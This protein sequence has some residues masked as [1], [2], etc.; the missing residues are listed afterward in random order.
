[1]SAATTAHVRTALQHDQTIPSPASTSSRVRAS[2]PL[3]QGNGSVVVPSS[4]GSFPRCSPIV[5]PALLSRVA[6]ALRARIA[7]SDVVKDGLAYTDAFD[8]RQAVDK[9]AYI[10]KTTDRNLALLLDRG[11][12][13]VPHSR[14]RPVH[15]GRAVPAWSRVAQRQLYAQHRCGPGFGPRLAVERGVGRVGARGRKRSGRP[16][17]TSST[18]TWPSRRRVWRGTRCCSRRY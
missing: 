11:R 4:P 14:A 12:V 17:R 6:E 3:P 1:M 8:G 5:Y 10:I 15:F 13:P 2:L 7:L 18:R 16:S 9:V